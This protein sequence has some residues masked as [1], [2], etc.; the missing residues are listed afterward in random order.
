MINK[1]TFIFS[2]DDYVD[3]ETPKLIIRKYRRIKTMNDKS[4]DYY[5]TK[6]VK[7]LYGNNT[8]MYDGLFNCTISYQ[9]PK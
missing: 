1:L 2:S 4:V 6:I 9:H 8:Q 5:Y 7:A 3:E